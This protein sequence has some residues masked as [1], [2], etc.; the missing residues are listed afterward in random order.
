MKSLEF[1][2]LLVLFSNLFAFPF[3]TLAQSLGEKIVNVELISDYDGVSDRFNLGVRFSIKPGWYIYWKNP[4]DAGLAPSIELNLP[5]FLK[6]GNV[7]FPLP[8]KIDHEN[9]VSYGY[10]NEVVL[11]I[12]VEITSRAKFKGENIV[13][14]KVSWV[15][16]SE[17]CVPGSA[18]VQL[19]IIKAN[20]QWRSKI[21][22]YAKMLPQPF[23]KSGLKIESLKVERKGKSDFVRVKFGGSLATKI[24]DFYPEQMDKFLIDFKSIKVKDGV[25]EIS[26]TPTSQGDRMNFLSGVLV[27][28]DKGYEVKI[29]L[30]KTN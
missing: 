20:N 28:N 1:K 11:I 29:D 21:E 16:C 30:T 3:F 12:P 4:G 8:Q 24:V 15:V 2:I 18:N 23:E 9:V 22:K 27:L 7:L 10:F 17:S 6:A 14:A 13:K 25:L 5:S 19:K 26:V